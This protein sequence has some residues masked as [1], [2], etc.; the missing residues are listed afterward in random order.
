M[1][2]Q[3]FTRNIDNVKESIQKLRLLKQKL[4]IDISNLGSY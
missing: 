3:D 2:H 4:Q 1:F